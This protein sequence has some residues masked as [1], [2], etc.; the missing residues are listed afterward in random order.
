MDRGRNAI[1][2]NVR[3]WLRKQ[4]TTTLPIAQPLCVPNH[5]AIIM[6]GNGRWAMQRGMPRIW[7]HRQGMKNIKVITKTAQQIGV[8][9]L[10]LYAF[11]TENWNRAHEEVEFLMKL[12]LEFLSLEIEELKANNVRIVM[13]GSRD[14]VP[15]ATLQAVDEA[16]EQTEQ[17]DGFLLNFAM[18]YGG[19]HELTEAAK[20]LAHDCLHGH[21]QLEHFDEH[22]FAQ[23]IPSA[24]YPEPDL[25]IRTSGELRIS[26]F[27]LWQLAYSEMY[28]CDVLWPDFTGDQFEEAIRSYQQRMRRYGQ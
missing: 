14:G 19:R 4:T 6:D 9:M 1:V 23:Y 12:P 20:R 10:T 21:V 26:N 28:F 17:N 15:V 5:V 2:Q 13:M 25:I 18:N 3:S 7:G 27:M 8:K 16:I 11:S 22:Q 24:Q